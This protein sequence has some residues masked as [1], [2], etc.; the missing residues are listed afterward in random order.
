VL[1]PAVWPDE[2]VA[3]GSRFVSLRL[4]YLIT[5]RVFAW[6]VLLGRS[7]PLLAR[8]DRHR[9]HMRIVAPGCRVRLT[10]QG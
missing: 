1:Q 7:G 3:A 2:L 4:L 9:A 10:R 6:L 5:V 8:H